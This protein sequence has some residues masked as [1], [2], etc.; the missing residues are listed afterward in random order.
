MPFMEYHTEC[1]A[2][3]NAGRFV[4]EAGA[5][6]VEVEGGWEVVKT[7]RAI[8]EAGIPTMV[9]IGLTRQFVSKYGRFGILGKTANE[10]ADLIE[11][12]IECEKAGAFAVSLE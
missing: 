5:D 1:D 12:A 3:R 9:H 6:G 11:L 10:A 8:V 2:R 4:K 7:A